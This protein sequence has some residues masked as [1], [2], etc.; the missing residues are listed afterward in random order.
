MMNWIIGG[1]VALVAALAVYVM[2]KDK[3]SGKGSC[4]GDCSRCSGG[5][6]R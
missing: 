3:K 4:G 5:C 6:H 2:V 1:A